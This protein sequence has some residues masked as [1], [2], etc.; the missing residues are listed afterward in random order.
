M[1]FYANAINFQAKAQVPPVNKAAIE[2]FRADTIDIKVD[3]LNN[4]APKD[5]LDL[6]VVTMGTDSA[7]VA[8][9]VD[10]LR[11][12]EKKP[13]VG[14]IKTTVRY[15]SADSLTLNMLTRDVKMYGK[16]K[17]DYNPISIS[18]EEVT[19]NWAENMMM[20]EGRTDSTGKKIGTPVFVNGSETY[21]TDEI[22]YNFKTEKAA[23]KGLVTKQ[24]EG[25]IHAD[26]VFKNAKGELFNK[27]TLYT[28]CNLAHPHYNII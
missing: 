3:S 19:V 14:D 24:G 18:A 8:H 2:S 21:E 25:F 27:T 11:N 22:K 26:Q 17:I 10:S 4:I 23:I 5:T 6:G 16:A 28:T 12:L 9:I 20:A 1:L 13:P 7:T 15:N